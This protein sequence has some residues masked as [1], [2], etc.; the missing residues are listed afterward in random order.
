MCVC[1]GGGGA[2]VLFGNPNCWFSGAKKCLRG[3]STKH[4]LFIHADICSPI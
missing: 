1:S 4:Q 2:G 3:F